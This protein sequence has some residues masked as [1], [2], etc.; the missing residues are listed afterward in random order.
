M[1]KAQQKIESQNGF[2][3][4]DVMIAIVIMTV[5][6]LALASALTA[7][8]I[9][10]YETDKRIIAKQMALSSIES[11][12]SARNIQRSGTI[13]GWKSIGN[14]GH[15]IVDGTPRGV[16]IK[17]WTPIREDLG[18]DGIAGTIDDA[19]PATGPCN[20]AGRPINKSNVLK[21]FE[22]KIV[23]TDVQDAES[24]TPPN[25]ITRRRIDVEIKYYINGLSRDEKVS[26]LVTN[27]Q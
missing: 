3:Y 14:V 6:V 21:G 26:T 16:F 27:Y 20:V 9:R 4:I 13:E 15:N 11:I 23:I 7:N 18:W 8:L 5:G 2:S 10:S 24:P 1:S 25:P 12:M 19:C 17:G 22:R